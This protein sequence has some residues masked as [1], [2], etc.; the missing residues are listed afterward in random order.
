MQSFT[1]HTPCLLRQCVCAGGGAG[2]GVP[3]LLTPFTDEENDAR[4]VKQHSVVEVHFRE[5]TI[6]F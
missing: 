4:A 3:S 2:G 6:D 1:M 5:I